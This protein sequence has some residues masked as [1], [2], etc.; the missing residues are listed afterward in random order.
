MVPSQEGRING[1]VASLLTRLTTSDFA[2]LAALLRD[3]FH[4][5]KTGCWGYTLRNIAVK[6]FLDK[7]LALFIFLSQST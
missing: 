1:E 2:I 4:I 5:W 3:G 6:T 7:D